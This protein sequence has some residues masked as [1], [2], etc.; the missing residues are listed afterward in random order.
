RLLVVRSLAPIAGGG[1]ADRLRRPRSSGGGRRRRSIDG[2]RL[3]LHR[4]LRRG[5]RREADGDEEEQ[6]GLGAHCYALEGYHVP[7]IDFSTSP[8]RK[9]D[10]AT[11]MCGD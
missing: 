8:S 2:R 11:T 9:I 10:P 5:R 7:V 6:R 1:F 3:R 4:K